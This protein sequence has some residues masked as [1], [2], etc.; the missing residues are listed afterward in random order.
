MKVQ[1]INMDAPKKKLVSE[2]R[3]MG[4]TQRNLKKSKRKL[5]EMRTKTFTGLIDGM[6]KEQIRNNQGEVKCIE[7]TIEDERKGGRN[8]KSY[9]GMKGN[10]C[11]V[12]QNDRENADKPYWKRAYVTVVRIGSP[13][14]PPFKKQ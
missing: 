13:L 2:G 12:D 10:I 6:I 4:K 3:V 8:Y 5:L 1:G 9:S 7:R 11:R 14:G